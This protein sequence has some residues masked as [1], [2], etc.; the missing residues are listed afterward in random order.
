MALP[1]VITQQNLHCIK[2]ADIV[3]EH[4]YS[5]RPGVA[6]MAMKI[7]AA[8]VKSLRGAAVAGQ[9]A[10]DFF[11]HV[12]EADD[13]NPLTKGLSFRYPAVSEIPEFGAERTAPANIDSATANI[14]YMISRYG[15]DLFK[16]SNKKKRMVEYVAPIGDEYELK[17]RGGSGASALSLDFGLGWVRRRDNHAPDS[18]FSRSYQELWRMGLDTEHHD[19]VMGARIVRTGT[20]VKGAEQDKQQAFDR[21]RREYGIMPQRLLGLIGLYVAREMDP[22]YA[23]ALTTVGARTLSTLGRSRGCCDYSG[24]FTNIGF[25]ETSDPYWLGIGSYSSGFYDALDR[26][27]INRNEAE[28]L[29]LAIRAINEAVHTDGDIPTDLKL[30]ADDDPQVVE[31]ELAVYLPRR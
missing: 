4:G 31:R 23:T 11:G 7:I 28:T 6:S 16:S 21:F 30:C 13:G 24:I 29:D 10:T 8:S 27:G 12:A 15:S 9:A 17:I 25:S 1:E 20:G 22:D 14:S 3:A 18:P 5:L 19:G 2:P 26:A